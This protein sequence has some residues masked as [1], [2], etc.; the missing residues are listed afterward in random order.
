MAVSILVLSLAFEDHCRIPPVSA[1]LAASKPC[2]LPT[3]S[4]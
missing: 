3:L 1:Y 2:A 4:M